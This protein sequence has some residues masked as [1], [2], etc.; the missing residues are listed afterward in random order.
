MH[1]SCQTAGANK[2]NGPIFE[3][4]C[5]LSCMLMIYESYFRPYL[6]YRS[7]I[8]SN[9]PKVDRAATEKNIAGIYKDISWFSLKP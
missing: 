6:K 5:T 4:L 1:V 9:M 8:L 3:T 2:V 7:M